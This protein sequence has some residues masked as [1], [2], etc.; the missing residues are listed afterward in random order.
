MSMH[1]AYNIT[2]IQQ[3]I[4]RTWT[5]IQHIRST[6]ST[7]ASSAVYLRNLSLLS[8]KHQIWPTVQEQCRAKFT[9]SFWSKFVLCFDQPFHYYYWPTHLRGSCT[10]EGIHS[11]VKIWL[12]VDNQLIYPTQIH[13]CNPRCIHEWYTQTCLLHGHVYGVHRHVYTELHEAI[14][15][16]CFMHEVDP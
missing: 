13:V 5:H 8:S 12:S 3:Q 4:I 14:R 16:W 6:S 2:H 9:L 1:H 7:V 10:I 15:L 11:F